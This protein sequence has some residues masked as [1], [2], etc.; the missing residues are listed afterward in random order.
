MQDAETETLATYQSSWS[1]LTEDQE[2]EKPITKEKISSQKGKMPILERIVESIINPFTVILLLIAL[3]SLVTNV[4]LAKPGEVEDPTTSL[5]SS[6]SSGP[7][8]WRDSSSKNCKRTRLLATFLAW[9]SIQQRWFEKARKKKFPLMRS[10]WVTWSNWVQATCDPSGCGLVRFSRL[11]RPTIR[12]DWWEWCCRKSLFKK[13]KW[14]K[15]GQS[16]GE[17]ESCFS[18]GPTSSQA[19]QLPWS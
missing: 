10:L 16:S 9:L 13:S 5:V 4:W 18:W 19:E 7:S 11:L 2:E 8:L 14:P 6:S 15:S 1:G 3:V 17:W 12:F